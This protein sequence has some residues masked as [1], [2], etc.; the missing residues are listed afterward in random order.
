M[1]TWLGVRATILDE[2]VT[3]DGPGSNK[4]DSCNLCGNVEAIP[5]YRCLECSYSLLY[6]SGCILKSHTMLPL[7]RL[8]VR[9]HLRPRVIMLTTPSAGRMASFAE[10]LS[11]RSGISATLGMAATC[12]PRNPLIINLPSS[13]STVGIKYKSD[14]ANAARVECPMSTTGNSFVCTGTPHRL[15]VR[16]QHSLSTFS[17]PTTK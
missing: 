12:V 1:R 13:T 11:I 10:P 4:L 7:H 5:L 16:K 15:I 17:T 6:C 3:L 2:M 14:F 9:S 8:E